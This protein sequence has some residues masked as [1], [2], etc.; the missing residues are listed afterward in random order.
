MPKSWVVRSEPGACP[1]RE[2]TVTG[3]HVN[4]ATLAV[5][6]ASPFRIGFTLTVPQTNAER[7]DHQHHA[8][9]QQHRRQHADA[10]EPRWPR[11]PGSAWSTARR[12]AS[13]AATPTRRRTRSGPTPPPV[14]RCSTSR[15]ARPARG[16]LTLRRRQRRPGDADR[17]RR[18][19]G[20]DA[21]ER[22]DRGQPPAL[23]DQRAQGARP[24]QRHAA[25]LAQRVVQQAAKAN[26]TAILVSLPASGNG[27]ILTRGWIDPEN[28]NSDWTT[29]PVTPGA[30]YRLRLRPPAEGRR[31]PGRPP[32]RPDGALERP[33]AHRP[34]GAGHAGDA[35]RRRQRPVDPGRGRR[36][37]AGHGDRRR[38]RGGH[39]DR[40]PCRPR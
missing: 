10:G 31:R 36:Q 35:R 17:R 40:R 7:D 1:P 6:D 19:H 33:R 8:A 28:R 30:F 26:L 2:S 18:R 14:T 3:E 12:S 38:P 24:H 15:R 29:E 25:G 13:C 39:G 27:T 32:A 16:G 4:T 37:G 11:R 5:A 22:R 21:D 34:P 23:R 20:V 9:H